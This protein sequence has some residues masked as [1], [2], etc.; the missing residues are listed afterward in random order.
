MKWRIFVSLVLVCLVGLGVFG[1]QAQ[2]PDQI[3]DEIRQL[4]EARDMLRRTTLLPGVS[5]ENEI[6]SLEGV[7]GR[8]QLIKEMQAAQTGTTV[9]TEWFAADGIRS[10]GV[11]PLKNDAPAC[12]LP[13]GCN[14]VG[15]PGVLGADRLEEA[16]ANESAIWTGS[17]N[18]QIADQP[19]A[20]INVPQ[21]SYATVYASGMSVTGEDWTVTLPEFGPDGVWG[22][23]IRGSHERP[24]SITVENF[25]PPGTMGYTRYPVPRHAGEYFSED[26]LTDQAA[27]A[28]IFDNCYVDGCQELRQ[29]IFDIN[30]GSLTILRY[31]EAGGWEPLW[32]NVVQETT[33]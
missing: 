13:G 14:V 2:G 32:T 21:G 7:I 17:W 20:G 24:Y 29:A 1:A 15:D 4:Q 19:S 28:L 16:E 12:T 33:N 8:L 9:S 31:T 11:D 6:A 25:G 30:D 22:L 23:L 10:S 3:S 26:Y 5:L 18:H 27:N